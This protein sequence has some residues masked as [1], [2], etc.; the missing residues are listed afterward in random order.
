MQ[1]NEEKKAG[2]ATQGD[3]T[4]ASHKAISRYKKK[5]VGGKAPTKISLIFIMLSP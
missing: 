2:S 3:K 4:W 1:I 5:V